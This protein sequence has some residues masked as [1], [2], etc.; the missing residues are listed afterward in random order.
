[1]N[2]QSTSNLP[3]DTRCR[4]EQRKYASSEMFDQKYKPISENEMSF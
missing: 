2:N 1:M 4:T 3:S